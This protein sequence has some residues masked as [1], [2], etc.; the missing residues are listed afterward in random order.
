LQGQLSRAR[1]HLDAAS[2]EVDQALEDGGA[3]ALNDALDALGAGQDALDEALEKAG[4][5][6]GRCDRIGHRN[7]LTR[8]RPP[9]EGGGIVRPRAYTCGPGPRARLGSAPRPFNMSSFRVSRWAAWAPGLPD[10]ADWQRWLLTPDIAALAGDATPP[11]T[12]LPPMTRR[13]IDG[14]GRAGLQAAFRAQGPAP[15]G[16]VVFASRWGEIARSVAL[17]DS[18]TQ[19]EPLSPTTFS[20]SVHNAAGALYSIA[21]QDRANYS[22]VSA[23]ACSAAAGACEALGLMADG[24]AQ[25]LLVSVESAL[26]APY[27]GFD[28]APGLP[29]RAWA[30]LLEAGGPLRLSSRAGTTDDAAPRA[31]VDAAIG[32]LPEDLQALAF[33]AGHAEQVPQGSWLWSRDAH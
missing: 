22:A 5:G 1:Q 32:A 7:R 23:G 21:R 13:R 27:S 15:T 26:P 17:L 4:A 29:V 10:T 18:L 30:A 31:L 33:L 3:N 8:C 2:Q 14:L 24:H 28:H 16:P 6:R 19:G 12:E 9:L 20:L 11:L 25:V